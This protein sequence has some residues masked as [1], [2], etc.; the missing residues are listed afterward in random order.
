MRSLRFAAESPSLGGGDGTAGNRGSV[1]SMMA[2]ARRGDAGE[3]L[4]AARKKRGV[5]VPRALSETIPSRLEL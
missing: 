1:R 3:A 4:P 2:R 5:D